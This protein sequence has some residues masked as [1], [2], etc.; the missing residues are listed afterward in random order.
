MRVF[1]AIDFPDPIRTAL[2]RLQ[3]RLLPDVPEFRWT[4]PHLLHATLAFLGEVPDETIPAVSRAVAEPAA[5]VEPFELAVGGL[6][7]FPSQRRARVIWAG[8]A[9]PG[10]ERLKRLQ[11]DLVNALTRAAAPPADTRFSPHIT[12]GRSRSSQGPNPDLST[13]LARHCPWDGGR[14]RVTE[15]VTYSSV[16]G[17]GGPEYTA[18][19]RAALGTASDAGTRLSDQ[20][21]P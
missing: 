6:G 14:F 20:G 17:P 9:G 1:I 3:Q 21:R 5:H 11:G 8:L 16:L 7:A 10:L 18:L 12:I 2:G 13:R 4:A 15:L 19:A